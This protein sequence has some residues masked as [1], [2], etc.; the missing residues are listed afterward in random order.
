MAQRAFDSDAD[1]ERHREQQEPPRLEV[2]GLAADQPDA[3][4]EER[5]HRARGPHETARGAVGRQVGQRVADGGQQRGDPERREQPLPGVHGCMVAWGS[6]ARPDGRPPAAMEAG[7]HLVRWCAGFWPTP[8]LP[9]VVAMDERTRRFAL[10]AGL[11]GVLANLLLI[12]FYALELGRGPVGGISLGSLNDLTGALGTALMIPVARAF[13]PAWLRA[14][15]LSAMVVATVAACCSCSACSRSSSSCPSCWPRSWR[16]RSGC[17]SRHGSDR[18][19]P[20]P[21]RAGG[22]GRARRDAGRRARAAVPVDV[23]AA[24]RAVRRGRPRRAAR[25]ARDAGVVPAPRRNREGGPQAAEPPS[26]RS[27]RVSRRAPGS[28]PSGRGRSG[29]APACPPA[30]R[31]PAARSRR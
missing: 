25:V 1:G 13:G 18:R 14:L 20:P 5:D 19:P 6:W 24:A 16:S 3:D 9:S 21:R 22:R 4:G 27:R 28:W 10:A 2:L 26:R 29:S 31:T 12:A 30:R 17:C 23:V 8:Q 11:V 15:G 7:P